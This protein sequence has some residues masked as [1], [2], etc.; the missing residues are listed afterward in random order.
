MREFIAIYASSGTISDLLSFSFR[1]DTRS[2]FLLRRNALTAIGGF[3]TDSWIHD[4]QAEAL[5]LGRGYRVAQVEEVLQ[6]GMAKPTYQA[7]VNA[8]SVNR[9]GPLRIDGELRFTF[10]SFRIN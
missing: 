5:L 6:W 3:P 7:Q 4:G 2:G 10:P 9:L 8:M 1:S